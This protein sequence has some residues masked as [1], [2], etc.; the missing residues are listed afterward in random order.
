MCTAYRIKSHFSIARCPIFRSP[1]R[2]ASTIALNGCKEALG[3]RAE[4]SAKQI[5]RDMDARG[6]ERTASASQMPMPLDSSFQIEVEVLSEWRREW[7]GFTST[8]MLTRGNLRQLEF[9]F[10]ALKLQGEKLASPEP[11]RQTFTGPCRC[12]G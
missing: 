12:S 8:V 6:A 10:A 3:E 1:L 5:K 7:W 9:E 11:L 2:H 4:A